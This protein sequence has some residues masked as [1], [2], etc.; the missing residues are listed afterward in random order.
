MAVKVNDS[1]VSCRRKQ[2]FPLTAEMKT[3][4]E[5]VE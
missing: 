5:T 2:E 4:E 1:M 3:A